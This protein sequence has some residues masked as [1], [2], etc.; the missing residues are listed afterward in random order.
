MS[1]VQPLEPLDPAGARIVDQLHAHIA[2]LVDGNRVKRSELINTGWRSCPCHLIYKVEWSFVP[3]TSER[4]I[5]GNGAV[6]TH[7]GYKHSDYNAETA[8]RRNAGRTH[9]PIRQGFMSQVLADGGAALARA[10]SATL[11]WDFGQHSVHE[12]CARCRGKGRVTCSSCSGNG[13]ETCYRCHGRGSTTETRWVP[14]YKGQGYTE[15]YQQACYSCGCSGRVTCS[16]C[17]GSGTRACSECGAHG[18]FTDIMT[19]TVRAEPH[20]RI[21]TYSE[22]S[23]DKLSDYLVALPVARVVNDLDFT[24]FDHQDVDADKWRVDYE[25]HTTVVE[26]DVT[27]RGTAYLAAAVGDHALA[28]I[29]PP[30]FDNVLAQEITDIK[31]IWAG[32]KKSFSH[33]QARKFFDTYVGLPVLDSAMKSVAK[34]KGKGRERPWREVNAACN[35][36]ISAA[37]ANLLGNCMLTLLDKVSPPNSLW[38][39]I[40]VMTLPFLLL[41]LGAQNWFERNIHGDYFNVAMVWLGLALCAALLTTLVAPVA[42]FISAIVSAIRRRS[43]PAQ[44]RQHGRNWQPFMPLV[45]TA[46]AVATLG[47]AAGALTHYDNLPR[48]HNLP[49][50]TLEKTL[51]LNRFAPYAQTFAWLKEAGFFVTTQPTFAIIPSIEPIVLDIQ[52]N[53]KR[54]GYKLAVTGQM[55]AATRRAVIAYAKKRKLKTTDSETVRAA[56]CKDLR[57]VCADV[58]QLK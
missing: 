54:L 43:L 41:F 29:R 5:Q 56:L 16:Q 10:G 24:Q 9:K 22:L 48:W 42:A 1:L 45:G 6:S 18:F 35:G 7:F 15:N 8:H 55:D 31:R 14:G 33:D 52:N 2:N 57:G 20:V 13:N 49:M 39:W 37:A 30:I 36:Y 26:L 32:K 38:S 25:V 27:L 19:V 23:Q 21:S 28:F 3:Y 58:S 50:N 47:G 12:R 40:G 44:Y 17:N 51:N 4:R 34:L 11:I 46:V 53:L